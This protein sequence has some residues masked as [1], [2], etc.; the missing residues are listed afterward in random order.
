MKIMSKELLIQDIRDL[1]AVVTGKADTALSAKFSEEGLT[2]ADAELSLR[3][4]LNS[5]YDPTNFY[6]PDADKKAC[7]ALIAESASAE[8]PKRVEAQFG[9]FVE[10]KTVKVGDKP[11]FIIKTGVKALRKFV[12]RVAQGGTYRKG[13]L[14]T[15]EVPFE[16]FTIGGGV[17]LELREYLAGFLTMSE[18]Q[19]IILD[20]AFY[21]TY[22]EI[23]DMLKALYGG[24]PANN[25]HSTT[26]FVEAQM[27]KVVS[28]VSAYGTPVILCTKKFASTLPLV[29]QYDQKGISDIHNTGYVQDYKGTRVIILEQSFEDEGNTAYVVDDEY[30]YVLPMSKES[31]IKLVYEG[32][33]LIY[34]DVTRGTGAFEFQF[35]Q[36][37]GMTAVFTNHVGIY[38]NTA[39]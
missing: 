29:T 5:L 26:S 24:L 1:M 6:A 9:K 39:L 30:A 25:K 2:V 20:Q 33:M 17:R 28:T 31:V 37:M 34:E 27:D 7:F 16:Y 21:K 18:L 14:D 11:K 8:L 32:Q 10:V 36:T 3:E 22:I 15:R 13:T 4:K 35:Q 12:T 23:Q 19:E 38:Q